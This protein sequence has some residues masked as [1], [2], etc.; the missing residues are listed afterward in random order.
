MNERKIKEAYDSITPSEAQRERMLRN[1]LQKKGRKPSKAFNPLPIAAAITLMLCIWGLRDLMWERGG[2][3]VQPME[4]SKATEIGE[5]TENILP[6]TFDFSYYGAYSTVLERYYTAWSEGWDG[7]M[8]DTQGVSRCFAEAAAAEPE[9]MGFA[10]WDLDG[11]GTEELILTDGLEIYSLYTLEKDVPLCLMD[12]QDANEKIFRCKNGMIYHIALN[13]GSKYDATMKIYSVFEKADMTP[14]VVYRIIN[15]AYYL[16]KQDPEGKWVPDT[17]IDNI[18]E[19]YYTCSMDPITFLSYRMVQDMAREKEALQEKI[20][21]LE[22]LR[23]LDS[24]MVGNFIAEASGNLHGNMY[25]TY[26]S[27]KRLDAQ[28]RILARA[29]GEYALSGGLLLNYVQ[30]EG[31]HIYFGNLNSDHWDPRTD[32]VWNLYSCVF[33]VTDEAGNVQEL[34][35]KNRRVFL[36]ILDAPLADFQLLDEDGNTVLDYEAYCSQGYGIL[37][38]TIIPVT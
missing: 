2:G 32:T 8:C 33:R 20:E 31:K 23:N 16:A 3:L 13:G 22:R 7:A 37:E 38:A 9:C 26:V 36:F 18:P 5:T 35:V 11:N 30:T 34:D 21:E 27:L 28:Y 14:K 17:Q 4:T 12:K 6:A 19:E 24:L 10:L 29:N 1:I 25:S 15:E